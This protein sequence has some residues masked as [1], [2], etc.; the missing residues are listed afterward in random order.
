MLAPWEKSYDKLRQ[1]IEKQRYYFI[2]KGPSSYD[3]S[4]SHVWM[5]ELGHKESWAPNNWYLW[6]VVLEKSL[7]SPVDCKEIKSVNLEYSLG[8]LML[9]LKLQY[10]GHLMQRAD[11]LEKTL[12]L[13][14]TEGRRRGWQRTRWHHWLNGHEFE[15]ALGDG[16]GQGEG[17]G[18][19]ACCNPWGHKESDTTERLNNWYSTPSLPVSQT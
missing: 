13:G 11:S 10:S 9:K 12:M 18:S 2:Y 4:S 19:L 15:Q 1:H 16:E 14:K 17:Q 8:G 6:I 3:F 7:E 5:W